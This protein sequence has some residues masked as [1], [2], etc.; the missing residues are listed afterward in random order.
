[1]YFPETDVRLLCFRAAAESGPGASA[2]RPSSLLLRSSSAGIKLAREAG[3]ALWPPDLAGDGAAAAA[4]E[5]S[6]STAPL[7]CSS[8]AAL[9][10]RFRTIFF[11]VLP[12]DGDGV[13]D[14]ACGLCEAYL[15][16]TTFFL[17]GGLGGKLEDT[18]GAATDALPCA[19]PPPPAA[20]ACTMCLAVLA[21]FT[22]SLVPWP[23]R[24]L[25]IFRSNATLATSV[26][27]ALIPTVRPR[28]PAT[29]PKSI[30][31]GMAVLRGSRNARGRPPHRQGTSALKE[32]SRSQATQSSPSARTGCGRRA[33]PRRGTGS[34]RAPGGAPLAPRRPPAAA[35][36]LEPTS[37]LH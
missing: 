34:R 18:P 28:E 17:R 32:A 3:S 8:S 36:G 4:A 1:M 19:L 9:T 16:T 21:A 20:A 2:A 27:S 33:P 12:G 13:G 5:G 11:T 23:A 35:L 10:T 31:S 37:R 14:G 30:S 15:W 25:W 22:N 29:S 6:W 26:A 24:S 7:F